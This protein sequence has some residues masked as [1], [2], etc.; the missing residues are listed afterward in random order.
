MGLNRLSRTVHHHGGVVVDAKEVDRCG[1]SAKSHPGGF[2]AI[3]HPDVVRAEAWIAARED[4]VEVERVLPGVGSHGC[5]GLRTFV[6]GV[7]GGKL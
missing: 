2:E 6:R 1:I 7:A 5:A 4:G 3:G